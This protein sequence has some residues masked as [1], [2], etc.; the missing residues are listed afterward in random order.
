MGSFAA[1][2]P[3]PASLQGG[4]S[5]IRELSSTNSSL[6]GEDDGGLAD[7]LYRAIFGTAG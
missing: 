2:L 3:R 1:P 5:R 6:Q 4:Y 7:S